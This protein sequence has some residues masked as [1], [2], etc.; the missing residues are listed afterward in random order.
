MRE[1]GKAPIHV[2]V[3]SRNMYGNREG[4]LRWYELHTPLLLINVNAAVRIVNGDEPTLVTL[5]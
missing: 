4:E 2:P 3:P 1:R 5:E